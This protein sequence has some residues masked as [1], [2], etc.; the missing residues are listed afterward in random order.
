[1]FEII[2]NARVR[3]GKTNS[4]KHNL[5]DKGK[6]P[7]V[8]YGQGIASESIELDAQDLELAIRRNGRNG[9]INLIVENELGDN[10]HVVMIKELQR[11]PLRR[12]IIHADLYKISLMDKMQATVVVVLKGEA[13]GA[14][15]GGIVQTGLRHIDIECMPADIPETLV[16]DISALEIGDHLTVTNLATSSKYKILSDPDAVL[17]T[18]VLPRMAEPEIAGTE[19]PAGAPAK[20]EPGEKVRADERK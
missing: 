5:R 8:I 3:A 1:M 16:V 9:L 19:V 10:K 14:V 13:K 18:L 17:V 4:Y 12:E 7:A 11:D 2:I 20:A 6:I 15:N